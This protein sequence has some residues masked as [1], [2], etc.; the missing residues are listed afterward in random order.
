[1]RIC[2]APEIWPASLMISI[3]L[4]RSPKLCRI[5]YSHILSVYYIN[6]HTW[7]A[8]LGLPAV[9]VAMG[10]VRLEK[11]S[12]VA[13]QRARAQFMEGHSSSNTRSNGVACMLPTGV[14]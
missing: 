11:S 14:L 6:S 8:Q 1:M 10:R 3:I 12:C 5:I 4:R 9:V 13:Q 7:C 2:I